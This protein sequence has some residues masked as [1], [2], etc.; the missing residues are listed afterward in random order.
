MADIKWIKLSVDLFDNRKIK[1]IRKIPDGDAIIGVWLQIL[2]LAGKT[3]DNGL[4]YFSE[5]LPYTDEMLATEFERPLNVIRLSL[6]TFIKFKMIEVHDDTLLV[7]NWEKYQSANKLNIIKEQNR[8]RQQ[9]YRDRQKQLADSNVTVTLHNATEL[10]LELELDKELDKDKDI[11]SE[12]KF[13]DD[14]IPITLSKL[15][16]SLKAEQTIK[17]GQSTLTRCIG[18]TGSLLRRSRS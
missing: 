12:N 4:V 10:E 6:S 11:M 16:F 3:N 17:S 13:S 9:N 5:D 1:Q 15:L 8:V 18:L 14:S 2:C 7:S